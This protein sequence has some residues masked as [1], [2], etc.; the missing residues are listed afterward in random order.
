MHVDLHPR[1]A[2]DDSAKEAGDLISACVHCGFCLATCPTYLDSG[3]ERDSPRGRIYLLRQMLEEGEAGPATRRHLDRCLTCRSCETTCPSGMQYGSLLDIGRGMIETEAP[4]PWH[5]RTLRNSLR[6]VLS[7]PKLF[8]L[9][10]R[11]GQWLRPLLP[12]A[13][14]KKVPARQDP[15][16]TPTAQHSRRMLVLDGCVQGAATPATN[17]AAKR[18]LDKMGI[19]LTNAVRAGCCGAVNYH[20]G[21]HQQGLDNMRANIDAWW[22]EV[23]AGAEAIVSC[24]TGCGSMIVDYGKALASDP[25]YAYKA[26]RVAELHRDISEVIAAE[27]LGMLSITPPISKVAVHIPC[28]QQHALNLGTAVTTILQTAGFQVAITRDDHLCCGSAGTYSILQRERSERLRSNKL[29]ALQGDN[30]ELIVTANVG[31]QLHLGE[32]SSVPVNH[33]VEELEKASQPRP[34]ALATAK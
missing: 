12:G 2:D 7:R 5:Q 28:S 32:Q 26:A 30:P 4:R 13:L 14:A 1:Y 21:A 24:A 19:T 18:L 15:G 29:A 17:A 6:Y 11:P 27:G 34:A 20:L 33:W 3:D 16:N 9:L 8:A 23:E 31:C 10:L 22:P 25:V